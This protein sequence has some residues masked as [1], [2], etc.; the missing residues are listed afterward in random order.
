MVGVETAKN[1]NVSTW[2]RGW[3]IPLFDAVGAMV[4]DEKCFCKEDERDG[5]WVLP[6]LQLHHIKYLKRRGSFMFCRLQ[7]L[8]HKL[9]EVMTI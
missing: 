7:T 4:M 8:S 9:I 1:V 5:D 6:L 2:F 3:R